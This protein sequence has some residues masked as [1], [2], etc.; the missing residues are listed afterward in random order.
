MV[1][2]RH[3]TG[4]PGG[5]QS[6]FGRSGRGPQIG[7]AIAP[8]HGANATAAR[9]LGGTVGQDFVKIPPMLD[10]ARLN[11]QLNT[12]KLEHRDL[13][14]VIDRLQGEQPFD[15]LQL[16]RLKKRKLALKDLISRLESRLLPDIIA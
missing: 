9:A 12:L 7:T 15:L 14:S 5:A 8:T 2:R 6:G 3:H 13:D 10:D 11:S 16:Q 1:R 4:F